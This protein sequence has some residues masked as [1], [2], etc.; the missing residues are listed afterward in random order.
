MQEINIL[1]TGGSGFLGRAIVREFLEKESPDFT[2]RIRILDIREYTGEHADKIEFMQGDIRNFEAVSSAC[3]HMDLVIH[4]AAIVDW[5]TKPEKDVYEVNYSGTRHV[6]RACK[7]N[8]IS[9]LV[10][11]STL[12]TVIN[13]KPLRDIDESQPYPGKHLNMYCK[14]KFMSEKLVLETNSALLRTCVLRPSDIYG[15][16]DP[17]HMQP[18]IDMA[19]GGFYIRLGNGSAKSQHVYVGNIAHA[20]VLAAEA[21]IKKNS[22]VYGNAYFITDAPG[23]NFFNFFDSIVVGAGYRIWPKNLWLPRGVAHF[24][25]AVSEYVALLLRPFKYYTPKMSRFAVLYTCTDF[26]FSSEKARRD[27]SFVPRY[28]QSEAFERT[29][30]YFRKNP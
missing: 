29:V 8:K 19:L 15:E 1:I 20:H 16:G 26:T 9:M 24:I 5:G 6:I 28:T 7:E 10:Y 4:T 25:G 13:G 2:V 11:T 12:D 3:L 14:S 22:A 18:L 17:Y 23:T 30:H 21:L 27:F